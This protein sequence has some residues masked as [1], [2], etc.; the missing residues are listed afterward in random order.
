MNL[1]FKDTFEICS[2][3][4]NKYLYFSEPCRWSSW[5]TW[6]SCSRS[7]GSGLR[8]RSRRIVQHA[9]HGGARCSGSSRAQSSCVVRGCPCRWSSW[10]AWS[11]CSR[12][13]G[14]GKRYK[15]RRIVQHAKHGGTRCFGSSRAQS[16][17]FVRGCQGI[18]KYIN[19]CVSQNK[20]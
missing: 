16:T 3:D 7:C 8:Y 9:K 6:S 2:I 5:G 1:I 19:N 17:C 15:S 14:Y 11:S 12:S 4:V 10:G 18:L 20:D 13:C